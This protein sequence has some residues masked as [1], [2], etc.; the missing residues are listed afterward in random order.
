MVR[1]LY[2]DAEKVGAA[3]RRVPVGPAMWTALGVG[4]ISILPLAVFANGFVNSAQQA[5][6]AIFS[7]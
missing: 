6:G 5:A 7:R 2:S 3:T 4:V 1:V